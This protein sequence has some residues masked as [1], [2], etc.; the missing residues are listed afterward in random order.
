MHE[1][2]GAA[3]FLWVEATPGAADNFLRAVL[4]YLCKVE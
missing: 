3:P 4:E 1:V 2:S